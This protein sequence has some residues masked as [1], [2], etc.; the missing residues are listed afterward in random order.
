MLW[1][2]SVPLCYLGGL[3]LHLCVE[4]PALK[5]L[6]SSHIPL[7]DLSLLPLGSSLEGDRSRAGWALP[8]TPDP[9]ATDPGP[10]LAPPTLGLSTCF[11][12]GVVRVLQ[13]QYPVYASHPYPDASGVRISSPTALHGATSMYDMVPDVPL[14]YAQDPQEDRGDGWRGG[15]GG[16]SAGDLASGEYSAVYRGD[17]PRSRSGSGSDSGGSSGGDSGSD[18]SGG[19]SGSDG[20]SGS[21]SGSASDGSG[22]SDD[23]GSGDDDAE[24]D[25]SGSSEDEL[26]DELIRVADDI[27]ADMDGR[28]RA[29]VV[30]MR[31]EVCVPASVRTRP[32][33]HVRMCACA[34]V[35]VRACSV[36]QVAEGNMGEV[37]QRVMDVAELNGYDNQ[38]VVRLVDLVVDRSI[39]ADSL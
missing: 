31:G 16:Q 20:V 2:A 37:M 6:T 4:S 13:R 17:G 39:A 27:I 11:C 18:S 9:G 32:C 36:F 26:G 8:S 10:G 28:V 12:V 29:S 21:D 22:S 14:P 38:A 23:G 3:V 35:R 34:C 1:A 7:L 30:G 24:D 5:V 33:M 15:R 25:G 19:D